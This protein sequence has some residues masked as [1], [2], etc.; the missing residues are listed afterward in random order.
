MSLI[1][2][3]VTT[4]NREE[5]LKD[6]IQSIL[7]QSFQDFELLIISDGFFE[8]TKT[9]VDSFKDNRITLI[10][11]EHTGLPAVSRN[12][13]I[14]N[15]NS[16]YIAFCD[17]DD[18]WLKNKL[19]I[20]Y[21]YSQKYNNILL[22]TNVFLIDKQNIRLKT[23]NSL[24]KSL[25]RFSKYNLYIT[26]FLT[27]STILLNTKLAQQIKFDENPNY[28]GS[29]DY[30]FILEVINIAK[31]K[32]I[33]KKLVGYRI[34]N[35]NIS[36]NK[37]NGYKRSILILKEILNTRNLFLRQIIKFGIKIYYLKLNLRT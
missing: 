26:N 16:K 15:A 27:L 25:Y 9:V 22:H 10:F 8:S 35:N 4:Y 24:L 1:T 32:Y 34:H 21:N 33:N 5:Y 31:I 30:K 2:V 14:I 29:E 13:G 19:E 23:P 6:C 12:I 3:V 17:D 20:Q 36:S 18:I 11:N 7:D 28:R 37:N